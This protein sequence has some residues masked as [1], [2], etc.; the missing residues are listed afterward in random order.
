[1]YFDVK[2]P[3]MPVPINHDISVLAPEPLEKQKAPRSQLPPAI[4]TYQQIDR[5]LITTDCSPRRQ[6]PLNP[7]KPGSPGTKAATPPDMTPDHETSQ[8]RLLTKRLEIGKSPDEKW[9]QPLIEL[10]HPV[11]EKCV[12]LC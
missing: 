3:I 2:L 1:V 5:E 7:D 8:F 9:S 12:L 4:P 11:E 6:P 10:A